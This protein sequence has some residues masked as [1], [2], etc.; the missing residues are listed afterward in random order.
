MS[1]TIEHTN[2]GDHEQQKISAQPEETKRQP[3]TR[4]P[5]PATA[6]ANTKMVYRPK[7][8][9]HNDPPVE[10]ESKETKHKRER[11]PRRATG[12]ETNGE[13]VTAVQDSTEP[14]PKRQRSA[15]P[16]PEQVDE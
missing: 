8:E 12:E 4:R 1:E 15:R 13:R 6:G 7:G 10:E 5:K 11:R 2:S 16:R 9:T 14:R 3:R